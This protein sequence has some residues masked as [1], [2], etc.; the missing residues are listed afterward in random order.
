MT[1][2]EGAEEAFY[3]AKKEFLAEKILEGKVSVNLK[4]EYI[5]TLKRVIII[6]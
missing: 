2:H 4:M 1:T 5:Y 3:P 6:F